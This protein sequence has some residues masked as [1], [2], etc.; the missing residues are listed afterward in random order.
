MS[1]IITG[2][3]NAS[4]APKEYAKGAQK[5]TFTAAADATVD[6]NGQVLYGLDKELAEKAAAKYDGELE[7]RC[8]QWMEEVTG[9][10]LAGDTFQQA[11]KDGVALVETVNAIQ[12]DGQRVCPKPST[13]KMAFKQME[14]ISNYLEACSKLGV[15][16]FSLFQTVDLFENKDMFAV[17]TNIQALGSAA[18]KLPGYSGP[19]LGAKLAESNVREFTAEQ[20]AAGKSE[21]FPR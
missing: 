10:P 13:S 19:T 6:H 15:P 9:K 17:L 11:L 7:L 2:Y 20:I 18:Q 16:K 8:R 21:H 14:N 3:C 12:P 4:E 5:G 1:A